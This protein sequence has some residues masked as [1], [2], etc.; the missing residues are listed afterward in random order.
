MC[1][2]AD[3]RS[4]WS[5]GWSSRIWFCYRR[6]WVATATWLNYTGVKSEN[7][8]PSRLYP[9]R[10]W[11]PQNLPRG[12]SWTIHRSRLR[13]L[14]ESTPPSQDLSPFIVIMWSVFGSQNLP[15]H[16]RIYPPFSTTL[17]D[18]PR[19]YPSLPEYT[20]LFNNYNIMRL[21]P[22][23]TESTS[24]SK[25]IRFCDPPKICLSLPEYFSVLG[26]SGRL[27]HSYMW[28]L[29]EGAYSVT[30]G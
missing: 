13:W 18:A 19:I 23:L 14:P 8:P 15:L 10:L 1:N 4:W 24:F 17:C 21:Y 9:G 20:P 11:A 29:E 25:T 22:C 16:P 30:E 12:R 2:P 6:L 28:F 3:A 26:A 7:I 27:S 5:S